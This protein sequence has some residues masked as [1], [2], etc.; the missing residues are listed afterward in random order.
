M[1][2]KFGPAGETIFSR[3]LN[4]E[5][6]GGFGPAVTSSGEIVVNGYAGSGSFVLRLFPT[7][8]ARGAAWTATAD[9]KPSS[10]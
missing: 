8:G 5:G 9:A 2:P 6:V 3:V 7:T 4:V 1:A 10:P